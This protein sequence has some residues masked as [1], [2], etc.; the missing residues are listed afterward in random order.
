MGEWTVITALVTVVGLFVTVAKPIINLNAT[1]TK[2]NTNVEGLDRRFGKLEQ[3]NHNSHKRL[4]EKNTQ[5][6]GQINNHETRIN[7]LEN[8]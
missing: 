3:E 7:V 2:L 8:K 5:Q 4:W 1:I 6:D